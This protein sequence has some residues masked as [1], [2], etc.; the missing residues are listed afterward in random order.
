MNSV[1]EVNFATWGDTAAPALNGLLFLQDCELLPD[2]LS[3]INVVLAQGDEARAETLLARGAACVLMSDAAMRDSG[4][5]GRL[6]AQY[7]A[8]R[9]GVSVQAAKREVSWTMDKV[10]NADF[11][12]LTPSYG[13]AGWE[14]VMSDGTLSG[15]DPEWW[16]G[17]MRALGAG[18]VLIQ[19]DIQDDDLN[20]CAGLVETHGAAIWFTPWKQ[21][22][23]DL[24]PW[25]RYGQIRQIVLPLADVRDEAEL[26][27]IRAAASAALP[28]E[29]VNEESFWED[30]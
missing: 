13:K 7:G 10:S 30:A 22:D 16:V 6:A 17:E 25:V 2:A 29:N 26:E 27:R 5:V 20:L 18:M 28:T 4:C 8:E 23:A 14:I 19:A 3:H 21:A 11:R 1:K 15:T 9:I 24:E 12:C